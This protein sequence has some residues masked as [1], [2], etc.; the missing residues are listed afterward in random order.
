MTS[1]YFVCGT[2][3]SGTSL[4]LG[5]LDST[6]IAG[7]PQSY[8]REPDE[9]L[10]SQKWDLPAGH[11]DRAFLEAAKRA[12]ST[13]NGVFGA[14]LMYGSLEPLLTRL[15]TLHPGAED[16]TRIERTF[17]ATRYLWVRRND[18]VAQAVSLVRAGQTDVW[19]I[20]GHGEVG[21]TGGNAREPVYDAAA[22]RARI[23]EIRAD[24]EAWRNWFT[25]IGAEPLV[26]GYDALVADMTATVA[27][28]L[29]FL[30]LDPTSSQP[31]T[32]KHH[33]QADAVNQQWIERFRGEASR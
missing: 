21:N 15:G 28:I 2:P 17:G 30:H 24:D 7:H 32:P 8:F 4:L 23:G 16:K 33:R 9:E 12:G 22:I 1:A 31:L 6:G 5:L 27:D 3:R 26:I 19:F 20:G 29:Q 10:W 18:L 25:S 11:D 14:K 13:S